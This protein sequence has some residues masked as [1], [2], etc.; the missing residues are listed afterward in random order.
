MNSFLRHL[1]ERSVSAGPELVRPRLPGPFELGL[2][3]GA[4]PHEPLPEQEA[5]EVWPHHAPPRP[6]VDGG[7]PASRAVTPRTLPGG[8]ERPAPLPVASRVEPQL[9]KRTPIERTGEGEQESRPRVVRQEVGEARPEPLVRVEPRPVFEA[10]PER[11]PARG[12][13]PEPPSAPPAA[14]RPAV[15]PPQPELRAQRSE[16]PRE[17]E[18]QRAVTIEPYVRPRQESPATG[19]PASEIVPAVSP[20]AAPPTSRTPAEQLPIPRVQVSIGRVEV[21]AVFA[22]APV[23]PLLRPRPGPAMSLDEYLKQRDGGS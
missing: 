15:P 10:A 18:R 23:A 19:P 3:A 8:E 14:S 22:P 12:R 21:R 13:D 5:E 6:E 20:L 2:G 17:S 16:A 1:V 7:T 4:R 9:P 11:L